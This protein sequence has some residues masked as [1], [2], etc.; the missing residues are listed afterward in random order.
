MST[1]SNRDQFVKQLEIIVEGIK[2][3]L[4]KVLI[5]YRLKK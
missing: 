3:N 1:Q 5:F 2:N 4:V